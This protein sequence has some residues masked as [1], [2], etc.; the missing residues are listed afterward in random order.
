MERRISN[1]DIYRMANAVLRYVEKNQKLPGRFEYGG[2]TYYQ[3]E[4]A[5]MVS[6]VVSH[7]K[8][9]VVMLNYS[10]E[11]NSQ[12]NNYGELKI[13]KADYLDM[14]NRVFE[15]IKK[16]RRLPNFVSFRDKK[17]SI[18]TYVVGI[19]RALNYFHTEKKL[20]NRSLFRS[21][22]IKKV[23]PPKPVEKPVELHSYMTNQGCS[24]MGQCTGYYC[25]CN[26]LQQCFYRLTGIHVD[27][28]TIAG[29]AGTTSN[30][31]GHWGIET[32]V[33]KF[34]SKY[35]K[36]IKIEW[37]NFRDLGN[38]ESERWSKMQEY[39]DKGA[40][41]C[42]LLYRGQYGHYEVPKSVNGSNL[43]ILNSLGSKCGGSTYCGYIE[44]RSKSNQLYYMNGIS[45]KSVAILTI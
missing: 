29:W 11:Y 19:C 43:S 37:K 5:Y 35:G 38:S 14:S 7:V 25:A 1:A 39:I 41:F 28:S 32:A 3:H 6:Y 12:E 33:A 22:D 18:D 23:E 20:P 40:V 27:E 44:T 17:I 13:A 42:H 2:N 16:N 45:Q 30:G 15:Y 31:T 26:S 24:G 8:S 36:N 10:K 9:D 4:I 34:N 21:K